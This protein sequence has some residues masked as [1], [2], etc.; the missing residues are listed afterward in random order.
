MTKEVSFQ[1][2]YNFKEIFFF[3]DKV[4]TLGSQVEISLKDTFS[5][6]HRGTA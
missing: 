5:E 3:L 6:W 2:V 4:F 1:L